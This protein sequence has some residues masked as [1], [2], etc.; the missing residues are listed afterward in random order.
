MSRWWKKIWGYARS[1]RCMMA[2]GGSALKYCR[3]QSKFVLKAVRKCRIYGNLNNVSRGRKRNHKLITGWRYFSD[4]FNLLFIN[5]CIHRSH[6]LQ[7]DSEEMLNS[8]FGALQNGI[9]SAIQQGQS[10]ENPESQLVLVPDDGRPNDTCHLNVVGM[11][12]VRYAILNL[13]CSQINCYISPF[14]PCRGTC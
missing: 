13:I 1:G 12:K 10:R 8:W 3:L 6:M 7:A 5:L 2:R 14:V 9:R 4:V 11:K